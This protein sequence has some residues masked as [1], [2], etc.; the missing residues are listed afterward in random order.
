MNLINSYPLYDDLI[1]DVDGPS[2]SRLS[3]KELLK[4]LN[5]LDET[6]RD[7]IY[8]LIKMYYLKHEKVNNVFEIPY[9]GNI[10]KNH[11][12]SI[13]DNN[14]EVLQDIQF[15]LQHLPH[16]LIKILDVFCKKYCN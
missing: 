1:K 4:K 16:K 2:K 7:S 15:D 3:K 10:I 6:H 9:Q 8:L 13:I 5:K 14:N 11:A 12:E